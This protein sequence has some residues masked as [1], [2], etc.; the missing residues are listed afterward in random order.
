M[1]KPEFVYVSYIAT[2]PEK[3]WAALQ[4]G[5]MTK[6]FWGRSR[7]VSDW[8]RGADWQSQNYDDASEVDIVGK[9][10]ESEPP[11]RLMLT[12]ASPANRENESKQSR[13]TFDIEPFGE[14][15]RLTVTHD[16][17]ENDPETLQG[18]SMGWPAILSSLKTLLETG[19]PLP[20]TTK[21]WKR[22]T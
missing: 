4:N 5:E 16:R 19:Q 3:V 14:S 9:V 1:T 18:I 21:R 13:V 17:L 11:K 15:V 20:E 6:L 22:A 2:T 7:A 10:L 12:W 8:T